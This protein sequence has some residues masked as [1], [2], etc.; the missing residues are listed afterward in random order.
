MRPT[1]KCQQLTP[2]EVNG[3]DWKVVQGGSKFLTGT[4]DWY[5]IN[6]LECLVVTW[7]IKK[8]PFFLTGLSHFTVTTDHN[9]LIPI[10]TTLLRRNRKFSPAMAEDMDH[11]IQFHLLV[12]K[13]CKQW[14]CW[15]T[16]M[17]L[18]S[19]TS[20]W[21]MIFLS[22]SQHSPKQL[23]A[24]HSL[25]H[26]FVHSHHHH[27]IRKISTFKSLG[28]TRSE[29]RH[30]IMKALPTKRPPCLTPWRRF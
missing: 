8:C 21:N 13:G 19:T 24:K 6:E 20:P 7:T 15:C 28:T 5:A 16:L 27:L 11:G 12:A 26:K 2:P 29:S 10:L 22:M 3:S 1:H 30:T 17:S 18:T 14:G 4:E 25:S 9:S 23:P